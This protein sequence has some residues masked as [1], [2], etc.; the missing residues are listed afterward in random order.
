MTNT[1]NFTNPEFE[2]TDHKQ[3]CPFHPNSDTQCWITAFQILFFDLITPG[4][5]LEP[6]HTQHHDFCSE[7]L[8]C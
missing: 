8:I 7:T 5:L 2:E 4:Y 3:Y 1:L 6:V